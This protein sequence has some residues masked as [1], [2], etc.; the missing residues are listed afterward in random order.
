MKVC[1]LG[2]TGMLGQQTGKYFVDQ[3]G[4]DN[5]YLS[6]RDEKVSWGKNKF[7][8][9]AMNSQGKDWEHIFTNIDVVINCA[10]RIKPVSEKDPVATIYVNGIFPRLLANVCENMNIKL[11]HI[12]S[13]CAFT[14]FSAP[15]DENSPHDC[16]DLYGK[17]KSIGEPKNCMVI[18][19]SIIGEEIHNNYSLIEWAK[20]QRG[21]TVSGF[22]NHRWNGITTKQYA[23]VCQ[24][25]LDNNL[26]E[27]GL[28]H[29]FSEPV[30][31]YELLQMINEKF[32]L[33]LTINKVQSPVAIDRT[34]STVRHLN[35]KLSILS[36]KQQIQ[37]L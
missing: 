35:S 17:T 18:R 1:I 4:Y 3:L 8:F 31:K 24:Q 29:V 9:D 11:F 13:D 28:F 12:T 7:Y 23:K 20:S 6:Y 22:D 36:I 16:T 5:V 25:I 34:L 10:G 26:Y 32:N 2:S 14:G 21:K 30:T 37:E 33:G 19:T 27:K 15:Y